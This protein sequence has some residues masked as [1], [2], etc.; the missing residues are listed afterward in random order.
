MLSRFF[1]CG[2]RLLF[3]CLLMPHSEI[4]PRI[5]SG[6][7]GPVVKEYNTGKTTGH[8]PSTLC[9]KYRSTLVVAKCIFRKDFVVKS[10]PSHGPKH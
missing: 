9:P 5:P 2:R 10:N 7:N 6:S 3:F 8:P 1:G 4:T